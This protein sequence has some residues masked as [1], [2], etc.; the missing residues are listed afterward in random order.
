M[1]LEQL[2]IFVEVAERGHLTQAANILALTPSAVSA[3]I[4]VLEDRY[5][6]QLFDRVGR[7]IEL[8]GFN[9]EVQL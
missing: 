8:G 4:R 3:A 5:G 1:T 7:G 6:T 9:Y 2:R